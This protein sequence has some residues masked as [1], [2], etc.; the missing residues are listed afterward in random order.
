MSPPLSR[1]AGLEHQRQTLLATGC[2]RLFSEQVSSVASRPELEAALD[3]YAMATHLQSLGS[4]ASLE[5]SQT[6]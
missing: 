6:Y 4:T 5:V 2:T 3:W 1:T